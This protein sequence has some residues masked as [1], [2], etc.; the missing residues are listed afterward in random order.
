MSGQ[1][2]EQPVRSLLVEEL[3]S[4]LEQS[5]ADPRIV[6]IGKGIYT[7]FTVGILK[8]QG[9]PVE[10]PEDTDL[11]MEW[12]LEDS[13]LAVAEIEAAITVFLEM[14]EEEKNTWLWGALPTLG[15]A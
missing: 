9:K 14:P 4:E 8:R 12:L 15:N 11:T 7:G 10:L 1:Y 2:R 5:G 13:G 6:E 3:F